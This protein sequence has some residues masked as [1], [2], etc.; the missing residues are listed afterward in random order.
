MARPPP[1]SHHDDEDDDSDE[2]STDSEWNKHGRRRRNKDNSKDKEKRKGKGEGPD[3]DYQWEGFQALPRVDKAP[4][5]HHLGGRGW[6][7]MGSP[8]TS[9]GP[10]WEGVRCPF[11][12]LRSR[13]LE[14][15]RLSF[16]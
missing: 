4:Y 5:R 1:P 16:R 8:L 6:L 2:F 12:S 10:T 11:L 7:Q 14:E 15:G 3:D 13:T 9:M